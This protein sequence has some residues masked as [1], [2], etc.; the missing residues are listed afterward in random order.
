[1]AAMGC[2]GAR[3]GMLVVETIAKIR[4]AYFVQG[5]P[6]KAICRDLRLSRKVVRKVLRSEA[7]E[8]HYERSTQPMPKVGPWRDELD[9]LLEAN[10][11]KAG[12][13]R[14]TLIRIFEALREVGYDG[15]YDAVRRYARAW[16]EG[17]G[18]TTAQAYVPLSFAPGEAYQFDWSHEIVVMN[19]VTTRVKVAHV[20]L[21][22]SRML[23]VRAYARESQEMVF[24]AHDRAFAF[25]KGVCRRGIYDNMKTAVETIFVGKERAYNRRFLQMCSH[26]LV[27]PVACTPASGWEKGQVENQVGLVRER[28]FTPRLRVKSYDEL[29]A[30]LLDQC[31]AWA[32]AHRHPELRERT[33]WEVFEAERPS[34]VAY[35]GRFDGFHAL[36]ASVS[37]TCLVRF[38][39][40]RYSVAAGAVGRPVEIRAYAE[41]IELRQDGRLVGTHARCFGRDQ[42]VFDPWH[43]VPVLARKPGALRNGAPFKDWVLPASLERVRRKLAAAPDGDRQM[44]EILTAVLSD[45]LPAVEA[46]CGEALREGVHSAAVILN[47]LARRREPDAPLTIMTPDALR[48]RHAPTADCTRYD[49]LRSS[50]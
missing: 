19:G 4:R 5:M 33:I 9:R 29:D 46:A 41:R 32:K 39:N 15:S 17:R 49:R 18:A 2:M 40:N 8:F 16:Q 21:C 50:V 30:W 7:T 38:D 42:T 10:E 35:A 20:R 25:F 22:H 34:L 13:D 26:Y 14:L 31:I 44:V 28:F 11:G 48:L 36:P 12:R 6:I 45:G 47:I 27:E 24:D 43:Y 3:I 37:K 1:M 23:Y